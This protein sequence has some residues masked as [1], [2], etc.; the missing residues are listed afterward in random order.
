[1]MGERPSEL[2][3]MAYAD[4]ELDAAAAESMRRYLAS[5]PVAAGK[6]RLHQRLREASRRT[7]ETGAPPVSAVLAGK[8]QALADRAA[9]PSRG[10]WRIGFPLTAVA[11][12]LVLGIASAVIWSKLTSGGGGGEVVVRDSALVPVSY[13]T[14]AAQVH[15]NCSKHPNHFNPAFPRT[16]DE[17]PARLREFLGRDARCPDL[18]KLGYQFAGCGPCAISGGSRTAH[19]LYRPTAGAGSGGGGRCVS[20][21]LQADAGQLAIEPRK[22]YF[23]RDAADATPMIIWRADG[24][25]YYLVGEDNEQL[26]SAAGEMGMRVRI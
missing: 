22:V 1:M 13:V 17:M 24:V 18:S 3:L 15:I 6:V 11:A 10:R 14:T 8:V 19:L 4:G 25:L 16:L 21:F 2:D 7:G 9:E 26:S 20:L 5:D 12:V 23:A